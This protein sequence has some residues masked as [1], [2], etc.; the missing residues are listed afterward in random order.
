MCYTANVT[1]NSPSVSHIS[2][3]SS[4]YGYLTLES[5]KNFR[6]NSE[7]KGFVTQNYLHV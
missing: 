7:V 5:R 6:K 4:V 3:E 1:M 2:L